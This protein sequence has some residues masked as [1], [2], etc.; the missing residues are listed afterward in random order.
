MK[1]LDSKMLVVYLTNEYSH[2]DKTMWVKRDCFSHIEYWMKQGRENATPF[3]PVPLLIQALKGDLLKIDSLLGLDYPERISVNELGAELY[4]CDEYHDIDS[5]LNSIR[6]YIE[7][8]I[9]ALENFIHP[10]ELK[11]LVYDFSKQ[12][13]TK[14]MK[15]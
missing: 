6:S 9:K 1:D 11:E 4:Y 7:S 13:I 10:Y 15:K 5:S 8:M 14:E 2:S 12:I 3:I